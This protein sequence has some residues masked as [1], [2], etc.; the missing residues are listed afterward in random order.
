[1]TISVIIPCYKQ[2][3]FLREAVESVRAQTYSDWE[4]IMA[5]GDE[6]S[7]MVAGAIVM[8]E[9]FGARKA[10]AFKDYGK[11]QAY[12]KNEAIRAA[13]GELILPLDA[14]DML[15][16]TFMEKVM[17][18]RTG[19]RNEIV[20]CWVQ[21]FGDSN[22]TWIPAPWSDIETSNPLPNT[23]L[24]SKSLW[25]AVGGYDVSILGFEDWNFW[26]CCAAFHPKVT[27]LPEFLFKYRSHPEQ[28]MKAETGLYDLWKA[29]IRLKH[30]NIWSARTYLDKHLVS[31][32]PEEAVKR[33][34]QRLALFPD[35][36]TLRQW[37]S[38]LP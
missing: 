30:P 23:S 11:G 36:L 18:A 14:D 2:A 35:N 1:V 8:E 31:M 25:E 3:K 9:I 38:L 20:S 6:E 16:P 7:F 12:A 5:C 37:E 32:M 27:V 19:Q 4:I 34:R 21:S 17:K 13:R 29:M 26:L 33:L 28:G 22:A 15:A 24:F 10:Y